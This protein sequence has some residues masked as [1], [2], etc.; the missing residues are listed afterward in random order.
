MGSRAL[1]PGMQVVPPQ[2][3]YPPNPRRQSNSS[4]HNDLSRPGRASEMELWPSIHNGGS[5]HRPHDQFDGAPVDL[6][7]GQ[8]AS[9]IR[10]TLAADL[11]RRK[12]APTRSDLDAILAGNADARR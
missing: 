6:A 10:W 4:A 11:N 7:R 2:C 8:T 3:P 12:V 5:K 1:D 9:S